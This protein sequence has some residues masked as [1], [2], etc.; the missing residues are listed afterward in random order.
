M[1][2]QSI[3]GMNEHFKEHNTY[4]PYRHR[5]LKAKG[6]RF[7]AVFMDDTLLP[8][9]EVCL[10][11]ALYNDVGTLSAVVDDYALKFNASHVI[12]SRV[13][14]PEFSTEETVFACNLYDSL[15]NAK[16]YDYVCTNCYRH[17]A[18]L[19]RLR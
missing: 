1:S 16:L 17:L 15:K 18:I 8:I 9:D 14:N 7:T 12:V 19:G 5:N 11:K 2:K 13:A 6:E 10:D 3:A 4:V